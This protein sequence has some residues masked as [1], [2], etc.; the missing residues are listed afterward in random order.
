[1]FRRE[2]I[3]AAEKSFKENK[4]SRFELMRIRAASLNPKVLGRLE[5]VVREQI[6]L[7]QGVDASAIDW[8]AIGKFLVM[9]W[10]LILDLI[11]RLG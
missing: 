10:P 6:A 9:I 2:L 1:M 4:L 11:E 7:E 3:K 8:E 5:E